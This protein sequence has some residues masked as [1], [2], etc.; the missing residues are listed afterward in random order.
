MGSG[1]RISS[2]VPGLDEILGGGIPRYSMFLIAGPAGTG[3][4]VMATQ[5]AY[6]NSLKGTNVV[7]ATFDEGA[8][9]VDYMRG[10]NWDLE[11]LTKEKKFMILDFVATKAEG[12]VDYINYIL[13][14]ARESG[15]GLL[16]IDSLTTLIMSLPELSEARIMLDFL[17]KMRPPDVTI[18]A[19]AN[20]VMGSRRIGV[21]VEEVVADGVLLLRRYVYKGES[22]IRLVVLKL[23]GSQHSRKY[24]EVVITSEGVQIIPIA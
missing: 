21:G 4:T 19:T 18:I 1:N 13:S 9:L 20:M 24:H 8:K 17:R 7:Y 12:A 10:F 2:G 16:V 22:R 6:H 15:A 3:K 11:S 5:I 23:R 14:E